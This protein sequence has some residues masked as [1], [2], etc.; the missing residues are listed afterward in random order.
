MKT[1]SPLFCLIALSLLGSLPAHAF[2]KGKFPDEIKDDTVVIKY[3]KSKIVLFIA[4][5]ADRE[6]LKTLDINSLLKKIGSVDSISRDTTFTLDNVSYSV[7]VED[8]Q[9]AATTKTVSKRP[10]RWFSIS[11]DVTLE[12][13][14]NS[15]LQNGNTPK[16]TLY[17][18]LPIG[19]RYIAFGGGVDVRL[20]RYLSLISGFNISW[21]NFMFEG[22]VTL[23]NTPQGVV[24]EP[25]AQ[26][27]RKGKLTATHL[28][29]PLMLEIGNHN[30]AI[31]V[32]GY[33]GY[34]LDSYTRQV[35]TVNGQRFRPREHGSYGLNQWRYGVRAEVE[36]LD[37]RVFG[38]YDLSNLFAANRGPELTP[39]SFGVVFG[40]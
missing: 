35:Y 39:I 10:Q 1:L 2:T 22:D 23:Q 30:Y 34:R 16:G 29:V 40:R 24:F 27:L 17:D 19:S 18:L 37:V 38:N 4:D 13:G 7:Q 14:L 26:P 28:N 20:S 32:G 5:K 11:S 12:L 8:Q 3:G 33:V 21:H 6:K 25:A 31:A 15:Y 36:I 9:P